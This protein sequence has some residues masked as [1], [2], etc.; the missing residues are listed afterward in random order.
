MTL[1]AYAPMEFS[2]TPVTVTSEVTRPGNNLEV[3]LVL[4]NTGSMAGSPMTSLQ[5]AANQLIDLVVS[6]TQTPYYS[7]VAI[8]PYSNSVNAGAYANSVRGAAPRPLT[9][10]RACIDAVGLHPDKFT[11]DSGA[12]TR[13]STSAAA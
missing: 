1:P 12:P 5:S 11:P 2:H 4:D 6:D 3:A 8:V 7:K 13:P 9:P 10:M